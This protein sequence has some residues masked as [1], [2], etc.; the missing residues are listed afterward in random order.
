MNGNGKCTTLVFQ[1]GLKKLI[2]NKEIY[3]EWGSDPNA[4]VHWKFTEYKSK[5][6][7]VNI[8][9]TGFSGTADEL[10]AQVSDSTGGFYLVLAGLKAYL[11]HGIQLNLLKDKKP[12]D[13]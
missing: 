2:L 8:T 5:Y 13:I 11:E 10:I 7:Y 9:N 3:I 6:T 1:L 12:S 4:T